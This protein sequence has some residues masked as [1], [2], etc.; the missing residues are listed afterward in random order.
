MITV[1]SAII[2]SVLCFYTL[3]LIGWKQP[4]SLEIFIGTDSGKVKPHSFYQ[5]CRINGKNA[6][7]CKERDYDGT[8]IIEM[9]LDPDKKMTATYV[10]PTS[11]IS[12][13]NI[14]QSLASRKPLP[15][16]FYLIRLIQVAGCGPYCTATQYRHWQ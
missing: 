15:I 14:I 2:L 11:V 4:A 9:E 1:C 5:A 12:V 16:I 3:Q 8:T 10:T 7:S 6:S 13:Y